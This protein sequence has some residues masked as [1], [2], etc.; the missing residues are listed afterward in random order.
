M[1]CL[2]FFRLLKICVCWKI[3]YIV[4]IR[5]EKHLAAKEIKN[6]EK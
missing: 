3:R 6:N 5:D 1:S 2:F 4:Y